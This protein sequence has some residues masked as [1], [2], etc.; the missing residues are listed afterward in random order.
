MAYTD[1][2]SRTNAQ[3]RVPEE[4]SNEIIGKTTER[5]A[6]LQMFRIKRMGTNQHR[7]PVLSALPSAYWVTGD[8]GLKQTTSVNWDNKYLNAEEVAVIVPIPESVLDDQSIPIWADVIPLVAEAFGN[9]LDNAILLG[10]ETPSGFDTDIK[11]AAA[12]VS[13]TVTAGT[14]NA[15]DGGIAQDINLLQG[16]VEADGF[17]VNGFIAKRTFRATVRGARDTTGQRLLD[18]SPDGTTLD[19]ENLVYTRVPDW[20]TGSGKVELIGGDFT[21]GI[22]GIRS[23]MSYRLFTEGVVQNASGAIDFN[24]MQQDMVALRFVAR[25]AW[26]VANTINRSEQVEADRFPFATLLTA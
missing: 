1:Q 5:S 11:T 15:A 22:V 17:D 13:N 21:Q 3:P 19:G 23:D 25:Y 8:T 7:L 24:L 2:I 14:S 12:A 6:A 9:K 26:V 4:V 18:V 10:I 20:E 16:K